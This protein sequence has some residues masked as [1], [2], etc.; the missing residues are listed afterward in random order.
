VNPTHKEEFFK[1]FDPRFRRMPKALVLA[2]LP[3]KIRQTRLVEMSPKQKKAYDEVEQRLV[4]R[5]DDGSVLVAKT[6]LSAQIRLLQLASS[7][8]TVEYVD[9][10]D[11]STWLVHLSEPSPKVDE[12]M[13]VLDEL[14]DRPCVVAAEQRK[15]IELAATRLEKAGISFGLITGAVDAYDRQ[16]ALERFQSGQL[17]VLLFTL[18]AGGTG[19]TMTAADTMI[20]LQRSW[21]LIDNM[22]GEDRVHRIGSE[23]HES[24][25]I[26][27]IVTEGTVEE[28]QIMRLYDKQR[29]L[30]EITR[31]RAT[32]IAAGKSIV[33]LDEEENKIMNT[34]L[35]EPE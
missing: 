32:L 18:K 3:P 14:G 15:I 13:V 22:Q 20:R 35:G 28:T 30:E 11:P 19:L 21:S 33:H 27:D 16:Q 4:T 7:Y 5:L 17:R 31:D 24:I 1:I 29:R 9:P 10:D 8:C 12:L 25:N 6:N 2:Q 23:I 26:I 34:F